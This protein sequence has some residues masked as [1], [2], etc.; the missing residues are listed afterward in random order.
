MVD[1]LEIRPCGEVRADSLPVGSFS[2]ESAFGA[3]LIAGE[4]VHDGETA[5]DALEAE[6]GD[7]EFHLA[8]SEDEVERLGEVVSD[9]TDQIKSIISPLTEIQMNAGDDEALKLKL[10]EIIDD[11]K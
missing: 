1:R 2:P 3:Q 9:L 6:I 4:Y 11:L 7:L 8:K 10:Q 5:V